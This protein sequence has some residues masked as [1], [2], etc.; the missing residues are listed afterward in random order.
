[1][2]CQVSEVAC[3]GPGS[4]VLARWEVG[5]G[6]H[7]LKKELSMSS[8]RDQRVGAGQRAPERETANKSIRAWSSAEQVQILVQSPGF[9]TLGDKVNLSAPQCSNL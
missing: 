4:L 8:T 7:L 5:G 6:A 1:M 3:R 2:L 9:V